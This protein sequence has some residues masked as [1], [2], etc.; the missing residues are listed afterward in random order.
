MARPKTSVERSSPLAHQVH[1]II[2]E[3]LAAGELRPG[4]RI[5]LEHLA[6]RLGVSATPVREALNRLI[7]A[8]LVVEQPAGRL[9]VVELTPTY[10]TDTFFVRATLEGAAA[11][12][13]ARTVQKDLLV[14]LGETLL[15]GDDAVIQ[16]RY[17][18]YTRVD[19]RL[20]ATICEHAGNGMLMQ[21]VRHLQVHIE[22]IR[23][24]SRQRAGDHIGISQ[25]EHWAVLDAL[26]RRD[27]RAARREMERHI[28]NAG[29]RI[30][31]LIDF[32]AY[33]P[34]GPERRIETG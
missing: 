33:A 2:C 19:T 9:H 25:Q 1:A 21:A 22:I 34:G 20:H 5:V 3:Q 23:A 24:F 32:E 31:E 10:V 7:Q 28:N 14:R 11:E 8:G 30:V 15:T 27:P 4:E 13:C 16:G 6:E 26:Q 18:I 29:R 17:D 12:L